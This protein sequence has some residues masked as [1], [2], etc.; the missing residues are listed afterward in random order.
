[1]KT[2]VPE[3]PHVGIREFR[4]ALAEYIDADTPVTITRHGQAVGLFIPLRRPS[5]EDVQRLQAAAARVR[6]SL[7]LSEEEVERI[8]ADFDALRRA[9]PVPDSS[10][11]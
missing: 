6:A 4:A 8:A 2:P 10:A 9:R 1:M 5:A 7:P 3:T 11:G